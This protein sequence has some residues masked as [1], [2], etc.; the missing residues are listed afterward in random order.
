MAKTK[1]Q[2]TSEVDATLRRIIYVPPLPDGS[3]LARQGFWDRC[4]LLNPH[5]RE[6]RPNRVFVN[7]YVGACKWNSWK[8]FKD[9]LEPDLRIYL[10]YAFGR[11]AWAEHCWCMLGNRIVETTGDMD[12]YYGAE[13]NEEER[14]HLAE[15]CAAYDPL[16][17]T[18]GL[19]WSFLGPL[20]TVREIKPE[21]AATIAR[22]IDDDG[23]VVEGLGRQS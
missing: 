5:W 11:G 17:K 21:T 10:G 13:L 3:L 9:A 8:V 6:E 4:A 1:Q 23:N 19:F 16:A 15:G 20:R 7:G 18:Q 12:I 14:A 2:L 22:E